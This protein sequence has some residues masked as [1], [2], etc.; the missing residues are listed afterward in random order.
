MKR[1]FIS[2]ICVVPSFIGVSFPSL[3]AYLFFFPYIFFAFWT[4]S[5]KL[6]IDQEQQ[7][8]EQ[9]FFVGF[10]I[11]FQ[12]WGDFLYVHTSLSPWTERKEVLRTLLS[13][14]VFSS[15]LLNRFSIGIS[16]IRALNNIKHL[17]S[18][19]EALEST[20]GRPKAL[21]NG[22]IKGEEER[23][24]ISRLTAP[25]VGCSRLFSCFLLE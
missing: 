7:Q 3:K 15:F 2:V 22:A 23:K 4:N 24:T 8:H 11:L 17:L 19:V 10:S 14:T 9:K 18:A 5:T 1:S 21:Y 13:Q 16:R 12:K 6:S 25:S 20:M